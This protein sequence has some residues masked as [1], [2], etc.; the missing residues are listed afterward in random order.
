MKY[1]STEGEKGDTAVRRLASLRTS[2]DK[3]EVMF[4]SWEHQKKKR[5]GFPIRFFFW[6]AL[7]SEAT[8][9]RNAYLEALYRAEP[10]NQKSSTRKARGE[11]RNI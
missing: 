5:I 2:M 7:Y 3:D 11:E 1:V 4:D 10:A 9:D 8:D 6:C